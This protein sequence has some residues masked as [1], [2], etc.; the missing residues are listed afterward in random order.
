MTHTTGVAKDIDER[1]ED[2][3]EDL[4]QHHACTEGDGIDPRETILEADHLTLA[5]GIDSP[6]AA[7]QDAES[8][9]ASESPTHA[10]HI[11]PAPKLNHPTAI[12]LTGKRQREENETVTLAHVV[13]RPLKATR[14]TQKTHVAQIPPSIL[15]IPRAQVVIRDARREMVDSM[16]SQGRTLP[17][18]EALDRIHT[19]SDRELR[20]IIATTEPQISRRANNAE[21]GKR[22]RGRARG[23][24]TMNE[25]ERPAKRMNHTLARWDDVA[26]AR[27]CQR[28]EMD[29]T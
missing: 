2:L 19:C 17:P 25:A 27:Y 15:T 4:R 28:I 13:A 11:H 9:E 23:M 6:E 18:Q 3:W 26:L 22:T 12:V 29:V 16:I 1:P 8:S 5:T 14:D 24:N 10:T 7:R 20:I 21:R